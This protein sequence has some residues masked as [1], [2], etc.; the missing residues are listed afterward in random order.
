[1]STFGASTTKKLYAFKNMTKICHLEIRLNIFEI[2]NVRPTTSQL[3]SSPV[4][5]LGPMKHNRIYGA[6]C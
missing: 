5:V 3:F 2:I 1:M 6:L 4:R